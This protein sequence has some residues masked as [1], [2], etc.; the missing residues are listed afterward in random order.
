MICVPIIAKN[1]GE[2]LEKIVMAN[3]VADMLEFRL[4]VME[5]FRVEDMLQEAAKPVIVT[6]RSQGEGGKGL[7]DHETRARYLLNAIEKGADLVDVEYSMPLEI[8]RKVLEGQGSFKVIISTHLPDGTPSRNQLEG[9]FRAL[10][11]T[12]ADIVKIVT[13]ARAPEDNLRVL[14][15]IPIAQKVGVKI[16]TFCMGPMGRTSRIAS[17][18]LGGYLAFASLKQGQESADG[19]MPVIQMRD[20]LRVLKG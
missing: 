11:A 4:D 8:R 16:I 10:A 15:L 5:S 19:Q 17:P 3:P 1:T 18:L 7:A 6:Y 20:I 14:D 2:A 12:G 13:R 9:I